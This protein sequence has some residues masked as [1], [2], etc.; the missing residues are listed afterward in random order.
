[1]G[2]LLVMHAVQRDLRVRVLRP[3]R[4]ERNGG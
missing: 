1:M 3:Q 2:G 4:S